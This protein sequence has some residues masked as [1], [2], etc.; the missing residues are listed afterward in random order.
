MASI[1]VVEDNLSLNDLMAM[2]LRIE[3]HEIRQ[4]Y[5]GQTALSMAHESAP[6]LIILD[7]MMPGLSGYAVARA[8]RI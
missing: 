8:L 5:E 3:G 6:D 2:V 4:A 7:V 1:L